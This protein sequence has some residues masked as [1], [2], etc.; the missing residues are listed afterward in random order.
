[1]FNK[2]KIISL[3]ISLLLIL[4]PCCIN[5]AEIINVVQNGAN[6]TITYNPMTVIFFSNELTYYGLR[7]DIKNHCKA[8]YGWSP[9]ICNLPVVPSCDGVRLYGSSG[10]GGINFEMTYN[11]NCTVVVSNTKSSIVSSSS[12]ST[13]RYYTSTTSSYGTSSL[14]N[15]D[16]I[17]QREHPISIYIHWPYCSKICGYCSFNKYLD[18]P[19][20]DHSR[21]KQSMVTELSN[22]IKLYYPSSPSSS[23]SSIQYKLK[24]IY[25]GGGTPS[26]ATID[27]LSSIVE[28]VYQYFPTT[29]TNRKDLEINLEL[30]LGVQ[31]L[32]DEDLKFLGRTHNTKQAIES[33]ETC[34]SIFDHVSFDMIYA[35]RGQH[36]VEQWRQ[37]L[38]QAVQLSKGHLSLYNLTFEDGT[39]F[40]KRLRK[41]RSN[42]IIKPTNDQCSLHYM[43][44]IEE[45]EKV[46]MNQYEISNFSIPGHHSQ[47]NLNYWRGGDYIGIGPGACSRVSIFNNQ[48]D[49]PEKV[50][51]KTIIHPKTWMD[52]VDANGHGLFEDETTTL[53]FKDRIN[54]LLLM[55]LRT[56]EG[57][58]RSTFRYLSH[59]LDI[60]QVL[61]PIVLSRLQ[62]IGMIVL[63]ENGLRVTTNEAFMILDTLLL[64]ICL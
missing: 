31:A 8:L 46:G 43:A 27:T 47:H 34:N 19:H 3:S 50:A 22:L 36:S 40:F 4:L 60:E 11:F 9:L 61:D 32:N 42:H 44:A 62:S 63:D 56:K 45:T 38:K 29:T 57:V 41:H 1:M 21:M 59:G 14:N 49:K 52:R 26:L 54:E 33:I 37:E 12:S 2:S 39:A 5:G 25:F 13:S 55:G 30:S 18:G 23:S 24:S 17:S 7:T 20:V 28:T 58:S 64:D 35:R 10:I 16:A 15:E 6:L 48:Q 53:E 51:L